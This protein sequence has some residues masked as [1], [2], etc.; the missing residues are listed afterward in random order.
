MPKRSGR[1]KS[2]T[3]HPLLEE[4]G[5]VALEVMV[6]F[7]PGRTCYSN[8]VFDR[9]PF[10]TCAFWPS[11]RYDPLGFLEPYWISVQS[12]RDEFNQDRIP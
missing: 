8:Y 5:L 6:D 4:M 12:D 3:A 11:L 9:Y 7:G 2:S 1:A 10:I